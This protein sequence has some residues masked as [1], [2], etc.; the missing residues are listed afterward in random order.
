MFE[1]YWNRQ[2]ELTPPVLTSNGARGVM[3]H[4]GFIPCGL[5]PTHAA[6]PRV[7]RRCD[8]FRQLGTAAGAIRTD[9]GAALEGIA[10][11]SAGAE[12][13]KQAE[14][15]LDLTLDGLTVRP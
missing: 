1:G 15:L 12:R 6:A 2:A 7:P 14:R 10:F 13:R 11:T 9:I 5:P 8:R 4:A 3:I